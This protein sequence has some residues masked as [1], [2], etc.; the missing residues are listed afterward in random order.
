MSLL[1]QAALQCDDEVKLQCVVPY[2]VTLVGD[3]A[4]GVRSMALRCLVKVWGGRGSMSVASF[5][6]DGGPRHAPT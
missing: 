6:S 5:W 4:T 1:V 2:L 3:A